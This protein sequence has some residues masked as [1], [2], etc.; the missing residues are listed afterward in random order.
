MKLY[1]NL[2]RLFWAASYTILYAPIPKAMAEEFTEAQAKAL[3]EGL[4]QRAIQILSSNASLSQKRSQFQC[5]C[6]EAIDIHTIACS[7]LGRWRLKAGFSPEEDAAYCCL[8]KK[9]LANTYFNRLITH[10]KEGYF[11]VL[12]AERSK[13]V[14]HTFVVFSKIHCLNGQTIPI[15]WYLQRSESAKMLV[16]EAVIKGVSIRKAKQRDYRILI[17]KQGTIPGL[18]QELRKKVSALEKD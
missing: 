2:L 1:Y 18:L 9:D 4:G 16:V 11:T 5:L 3:I 17:R 8:F 6:E 7:I 12:T 14:P 15:Q 13:K 10:Y